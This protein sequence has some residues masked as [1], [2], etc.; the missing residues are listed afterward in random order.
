MS[1]MHRAR[2]GCSCLPPVPTTR[3]PAQAAKPRAAG[4][5]SRRH[6]FTLFGVEGTVKGPH[7][8]TPQRERGHLQL[9]S[10]REFRWGWLGEGGRVGSQLRDSPHGCPLPRQQKP[11]ADLKP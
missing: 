1:V 4:S 5:G 8:T 6:S 3:T 10:P 2:G 7:V 11:Q 9:Q